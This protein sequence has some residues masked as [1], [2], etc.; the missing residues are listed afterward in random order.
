MQ[1]WIFSSFAHHLTLFVHFHW[2]IPIWHKK[3]IKDLNHHRC[4]HYCFTFCFFFFVLITSTQLGPI[5][6]RFD[7]IWFVLNACSWNV[8]CVFAI[9]RQCCNVPDLHITISYRPDTKNMQKCWQISQPKNF[10]DLV[11]VDK[12]HIHRSPR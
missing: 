8:Q 4:M 11:L 12:H 5:N 6:Y 1:N 9:M 3:T 2:K 7:Q 10:R